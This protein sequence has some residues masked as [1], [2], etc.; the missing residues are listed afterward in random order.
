M[1]VNEP[2]TGKE[3]SY[4]EDYNILS[5][6]TPSSHITHVSKD[7]VS[8]SGFTEEEL[9]GQPHNLVRH[10]DMPKEAF[11]DMWDHLKAQKSWMGL[12][13]NRCKNGDHYW[14]D[15]FASP[16]IQDGKTKEYQSVRLTPKRKHVDNAEKLYAQIRAGK[17][18]LQLKLPR[19]RL[20]QRA[21]LTLI[22]CLIVAFFLQTVSPIAALAF[23]FC[24]SIASIFWLTRPLEALSQDARKVFDNPLMELI[25]NNKVNDI[26]EIKLAMKM[27][28][29]EVNAIV[30]RIQDS[31]IQLGAS[32]EISSKNGSETADNLNQ[33]IKETE[34]VATAVSQMNTTANDILDNAITTSDA[35]KQANTATTD[36]L[37]AVSETVSAIQNLAGQL[38]NASQVIGQLEEHGRTIN[39]VLSVIE[40]VAEQTNLLALNA[41]IEAARAGEQ[42]RGFAVVAD[43]VRELAKRSQDSTK[44]IQ[45]V[46]TQIQGATANAVSAMAEGNKQ[47]DICVDSAERTGDKLRASSEQVKGISNQNG[48]IATAI[49]E[50]V[51]VSGEMDKNIQFINDVCNSSASLANE[52]VNECNGLNNQ[53]NEQDRLVKQFR[54]L[55]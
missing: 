24:S 39:E 12:V 34:L 7:F 46:I 1:R 36:G 23:L 33:Q 51:Q 35:A 8:L 3:V 30:G 4:P 9:L 19:T 26:S 48:Q 21:V 13:K 47:A 17:M 50:L 27:R 16:I 40:G 37:Q 38:N 54:R 20:W 14:V 6:V 28:Q 22:P 49:K 5:I 18:P 15:A 44:E 11:K 31:N 25:Y 29:F 42:G 53:L 10:P 52:T 32:A 41:A 45:E 43:E 2:V 55:A